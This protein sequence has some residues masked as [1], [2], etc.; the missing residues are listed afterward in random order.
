VMLL[1][2]YCGHYLYFELPYL[3]PPPVV[4]KNFVC[5]LGSFL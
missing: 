2:E 1:Q 3:F 5:W 4:S